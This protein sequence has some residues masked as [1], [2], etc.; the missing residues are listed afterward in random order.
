M[1]PAPDLS[2]AVGPPLST[3]RLNTIACSRQISPARCHAHAWLKSGADGPWWN[4]ILGAPR[5]SPY[6]LAISIK[7]V[8]FDGF[9]HAGPLSGRYTDLA[10]GQH[11]QSLW[12][13]PGTRPS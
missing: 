13:V 11:Q 10:L 9:P 6:R 12:A 1:V 2:R 3:V 5:F 7:T 4:R 8:W